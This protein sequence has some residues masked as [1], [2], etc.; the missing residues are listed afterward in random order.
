MAAGRV[1]IIGAGLAGLAAAVRLVGQGH[2]VILHEAAPQPGGRCR[3]YFDSELECRIDNGN[4]LV[5][6]ANAAAVDYLDSIG[7]GATMTGPATPRLD[8]VDLASDERWAL[9]PNQGRIPWW[10]LDPRRRVPGTSAAD[11]LRVVRLRHAGADATIADR[12]ELAGPLFRR[13]WQPFAVAVL[14]TEVETASAAF[15]WQMLRESFGGGG[16]ALRPLVPRQGLSESFIDPALSLLEVQN[17]EL[18]LGR[19]LRGFAFAA[20]AVAALDFEDGPISLGAQDSVILAVPAPIAARLVPDLTVPTEF[21]A[22]VNAH[23]RFEA[24]GELPLLL[25]VVGGT[26]EWI[27]RK[28]GVVSVTVSAADR[29]IDTPADALAQTLWRDVASA[30]GIDVALPKWRI[31][32]EKRATF[33][34]TPAQ[35]RRRPGARTRWRNLFLA[36]DWTATG[37]PATI[38]GAIRAGRTAAALVGS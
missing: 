2:R 38:E 30:Y 28:T 35:L 3:S 7:A 1:H 9:A 25:G 4:H 16:T 36:G 26:A 15:L 12:R 10:I 27:F 23:Y 21:R 22:I 20:D 19:R 29:L 8:F 13:L 11:Y 18:H 17:A 6:T 31:V 14:N 32:K 24:S 5:L 37:M 33:A 34:A